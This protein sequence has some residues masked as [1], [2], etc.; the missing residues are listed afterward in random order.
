MA[1]NKGK[2]TS[3][4]TQLNMD[5]P[6]Q[7]PTENESLFD[8]FEIEQTVDP[9][10]MEDLKEEQREEKAKHATKNTSSSEKK[11]KTGM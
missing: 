9:I 6:E 5:N 10:P 11:Y 4:K 7:Y 2:S 8:K 3:N 1:E